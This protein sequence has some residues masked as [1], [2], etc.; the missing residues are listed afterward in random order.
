MYDKVTQLV[1][2]GMTVDVV[3]L[4]FS[5]AFDAV[6]HS[7][8]LDKLSSTQLEKSIVCWVSDWLRGQAQRVIANGVTPH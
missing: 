1:G 7:I 3:G 6:S 4:D 5:S 2:Q 8:L